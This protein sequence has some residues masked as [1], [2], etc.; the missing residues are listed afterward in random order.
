MKKRYYLS[1]LSLYPLI[2]TFDIVYFFMYR[3]VEILVITASAHFV[4]F[5]LMNFVGTYF[6]Y[7]PIDR[8]F[9]HSAATEQARKRIRLLTRYSTGWIFFLGALYVAIS[10]IVLFLFPQN[11]EGFYPEKVPLI[12]LFINMIPSLLFMALD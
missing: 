3:S 1:M 10:F 6:I 2:L 11:V 5:G 9:I 7:K 4:L 8:A 12:F